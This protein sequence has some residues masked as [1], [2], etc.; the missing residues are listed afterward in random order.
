M[1]KFFSM[2]FIATLLGLVFTA[3]GDDKDE[4]ELPTTQN[5]ESVHENP[6]DSYYVFDI[7]MN[8]NK[9]T[10]Y[11]HNIQFA[12]APHKMTLRVEVPVSLNSSKDAYVMAGTDLVADMEMPSVGWVPMTD[13]RYHLN[14]LTCTVNPGAKSYSISFEAHGGHFSDSGDLTDAAHLEG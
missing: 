5:L 11:M 6:T 9:G 12:G 3:C 14:N 2:L 8:T 1:K 13:E 10:I 7:D 4:P